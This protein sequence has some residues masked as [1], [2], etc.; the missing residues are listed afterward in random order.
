MA[1]RLPV[2]IISGIV[3]F[4]ILANVAND[5]PFA[6]ATETSPPGPSATV[7]TGTASQFL[8][9]I[10]G[11]GVKGNLKPGKKPYAPGTRVEFSF[12]PVIGYSAAMVVLDGKLVR[13]TG[14]IDMSADHWLWAFGNPE[15]GTTFKDVMTVPSDVTKIPYP[16][17]YQKRPSFTFKVADPY[18]ALT[19]KVIAYP[20]SYLGAFPMPPI[21]G[22]PL[23]P[24]ILRGV[25]LRDYWGG[26]GW[27]NNPSLNNECTGSMYTAFIESLKR[28][29]KLGADH[30]IM[31]QT[32]IMEDVNAAELRFLAKD[33]WI[34]DTDLAWIAAQA[35]AAGLKLHEYICIGTDAKHQPLP[36]NP[37]PEWAA[38]FFD[39]WTKFIVGRAVVAQRNGIEAIT[40]DWSAYYLDLTS[41]NSLYV[42]KMTEL[43]RRVRRVFSGKTI[44]GTAYTPSDASSL[45][46]N[47]DWV[48]KGIFYGI[49]SEENSQL[50]VSVVKKRTQ[51]II[52]WAA[53]SLGAD[54]PPMVWGLA[55]GSYRNYLLGGWLEDAFCV[56]SPDDCSQRKVRT[57]FSVQAITYEAALEA[58]AEQ[59]LLKTASVE[60]FG[61]WYTDV[62]RPKDSFPNLSFSFRNKPAESIVYEWF[63]R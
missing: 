40:L 48:C 37:S 2:S 25:A 45:L 57:D 58:I 15:K 44:V 56:P 14:T 42:S 21:N 26:G 9:T 4:G 34:S 41:M 1:W 29:K 10:I 16:E 6:K 50:S 17:F 18:C 7:H 54:A 5:T 11:V 30:V 51:E 13:S 12:T 22:A 28:F 8:R 27:L 61:Y 49:S 32:A 35:R 20:S 24:G 63:K 43:A 55:P 3:A 52:G 53:A 62:I 36:Q 46:K 38:K 47:I 60:A 39:A 33:M 23:P 59:A 19:S 31:Y